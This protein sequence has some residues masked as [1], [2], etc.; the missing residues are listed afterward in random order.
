MDR[1]SILARGGASVGE[2][3]LRFSRS[4]RILQRFA[5]QLMFGLWASDSV[6]VGFSLALSRGRWSPHCARRVSFSSTRSG[7]SSIERT[8]RSHPSVATTSASERWQRKARPYFGSAQ[9]FSRQKLRD[10]PNEWRT[11]AATL[12][13]AIRVVSRY[14]RLRQLER[15]R[16]GLSRR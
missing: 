13:I 10:I 4:V 1:S 8:S 15:D 2:G 9:S 12:S 14:R 5:I 11:Q 6:H 16:L 3:H 7:S